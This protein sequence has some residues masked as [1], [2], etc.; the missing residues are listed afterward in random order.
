MELS[1]CWHALATWTEDGRE[2]I[3][4]FSRALDC[5]RAE[6]AATPPHTPKERWTAVHMEADCLFGRVHFHEDAPDAAREF[7]TQ[8]LPLSQQAET[9]RTA[10]GIAHDDRLEGRIAELL[11]QLPDES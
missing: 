2:R 5:R 7:L 8:A 1:L 9:L 11:L 3:G 4:Y 6:T 10:A